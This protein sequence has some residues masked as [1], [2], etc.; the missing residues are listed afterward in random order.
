MILS[1]LLVLLAAGWTALVGLRA[2]PGS[3]GRVRAARWAAGL[4]I[5]GAALLLPSYVL[6]FAVGLGNLPG[7]ALA[8]PSLLIP[9]PFLC[10]V[11]FG[12]VALVLAPSR[13]QR[14][15]IVALVLLAALLVVVVWGR[16]FG[17]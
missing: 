16:Q 15:L 11:A 17:L 12:G 13:L 9:V 2:A 14:G 5:A 7:G 3:P 8:W 6:A 10:L 1:A 4:S